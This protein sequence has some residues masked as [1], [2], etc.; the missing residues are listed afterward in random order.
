[1]KAKTTKIALTAEQ[2]AAKKAAA[3]AKAK[4]TKAAKNAAMDPAELKAKRQAAAAKA[5]ATKAAKKAQAEAPAPVVA[6][7]V[8][9]VA[10][11]VAVKPR[12]KSGGWMRQAVE[13]I[14]AHTTEIKTVE[15]TPQGKKLWLTVN[16]QP[17]YWMGNPDRANAV[18]ARLLNA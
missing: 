4:A 13:Y 14:K 16:G 11:P 3:I 10:E 5:K 15:V 17:V 9:V 1:M 6:P 7:V 12:A 18:A 2:Q 8:E